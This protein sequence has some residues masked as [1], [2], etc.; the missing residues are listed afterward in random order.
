MKMSVGNPKAS[1]ED[2]GRY[3]IGWEELE[4]LEDYE[5]EIEKMVEIRKDLFKKVKKIEKF[6]RNKRVE[7]NLD[8]FDILQRFEANTPENPMDYKIDIVTNNLI[9]K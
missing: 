1:G 2:I 9:K 7:H 3:I 5:E 8:K 6:Q 4:E